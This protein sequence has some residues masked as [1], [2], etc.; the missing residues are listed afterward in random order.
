[1]ILSLVVACLPVG[2]GGDETDGV[3][4]LGLAE[5]AASS[6][7]PVTGGPDSGGPD[8]VSPL[9]VTVDGN[10]V[11]VTHIVQESCGASFVGASVAVSGATATVS[12]D[13]STVDD[14]PC[15]WAL[16]YTLSGFSAGE[17]TLVAREDAVTFTV[18]P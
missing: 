9:S 10:A 6:E 18:D 1:M 14:M 3:T 7:P 13:F 12:Y 17:W 4:E 5:F 15:A 16:T 8:A 2:L 11:A